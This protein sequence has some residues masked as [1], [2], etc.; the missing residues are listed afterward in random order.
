[1]GDNIQCHQLPYSF[2][3]SLTVAEEA[4]QKHSPKLVLLFADDPSHLSFVLYRYIRNEIEPGWTDNDDESLGRERIIEEGPNL[5]ISKFP[6]MQILNSWDDD[7]IE[8]Q[9]KST[10]S[11]GPRGI[12]AY[13]SYH[14]ESQI[15]ETDR[16]FGLVGL[17]ECVD[18]HDFLTEDALTFAVKKLINKALEMQ[19]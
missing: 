9:T 2:K 5:F 14:L 17:P 18:H 11:M 6:S 10:M 1:M 13:L 3:N 7:L 16:I 4:I 8:G 15:V 19:K 12:E